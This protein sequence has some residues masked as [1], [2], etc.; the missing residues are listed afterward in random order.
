M[1]QL[2]RQAGEFVER[3]DQP[4]RQLRALRCQEGVGGL[5]DV[6]VVEGVYLRAVLGELRTADFRRGPRSCG[7][8]TSRGDVLRQ[9]AGDVIAICVECHFTSV[10]PF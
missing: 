3:L 2:R 10:S 5:K 9:R 7:R 4:S 1:I 6:L 8:Y